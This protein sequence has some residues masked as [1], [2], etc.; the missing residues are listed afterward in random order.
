M[1]RVA[2]FAVFAAVLCAGCTTVCPHGRR[3]PRV[4]PA[5]AGAWIYN[6][7]PCAVFQEGEMLILINERGALASA[8]KT[9]DRTFEVLAGDGWQTGLVGELDANGNSIRWY[10]RTTWTR[11]RP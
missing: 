2:L 11:A 1:K 4:A 3:A 10:N 9:G 8:R 6:D 7:L 5:P